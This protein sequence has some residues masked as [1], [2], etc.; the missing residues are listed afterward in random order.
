[1]PKGIS[2][3]LE[4]VNHLFGNKTGNNCIYLNAEKIIKLQ[5]LSAYLRMSKIAN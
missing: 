1:M 2:D 4:N 3:A 5:A